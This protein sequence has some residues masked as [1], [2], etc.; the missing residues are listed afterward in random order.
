M[1]QSLIEAPL[2]VALRLKWNRRAG[3]RKSD[4]FEGDALLE[5]YDEGLDVLNYVKQLARE[6][7]PLQSMV[8]LQEAG[9]RIVDLCRILWF[10]RKDEPWDS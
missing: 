4:R 2:D 7:A 1:Y 6:G 8:E 9:Y 10:D 5:L 3:E